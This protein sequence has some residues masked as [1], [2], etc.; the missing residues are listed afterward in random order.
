MQAVP[1]LLMKGGAAGIHAAALSDG[2]ALA[3]KIDDGTAAARTPVLIEVLARLGV[4]P[5]QLAAAPAEPVLGGGRV[6]GGFRM[7]PGALD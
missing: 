6:V 2:S 7:Q 5:E 1:G 3:L 4:S